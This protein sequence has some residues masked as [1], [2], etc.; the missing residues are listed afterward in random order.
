MPSSNSASSEQLPLLS[1]IPY[2]ASKQRLIPEQTQPQATQ[3]TQQRPQ[4]VI[5]I[6]VLITLTDFIGALAAGKF[7]QFSPPF[8]HNSSQV[9]LASEITGKHNA[10]AIAV[11]SAA[12]G[13]SH[14]HGSAATFVPGVHSVH[15]SFDSQQICIQQTA[16]DFATLY[17]T[18]RRSA[19]AALP[20]LQSESAFSHRTLA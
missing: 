5:A 8:I 16:V 1:E 10:Y 6:P 15:I 12:P 19:D 4:P 18:M 9:E 7:Q 11:T 13:P 14:Q 2:R 3:P 20:T 17:I